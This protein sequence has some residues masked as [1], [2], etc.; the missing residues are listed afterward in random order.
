[1]L[2]TPVTT[3]SEVFRDE[4]V[5]SKDND[6]ELKVT[7]QKKKRKKNKSIQISRIDTEMSPQNQKLPS[8]AYIETINKI[9]KNSQNSFAIYQSSPYNYKQVSMSQLAKPENEVPS[10]SIEKY[11]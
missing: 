9:Y 4:V 7:E 2:K 11:K 3:R 6:L 1:M 10:I 8:N 5:A